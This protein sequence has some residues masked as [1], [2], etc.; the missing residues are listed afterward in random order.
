[1]LS[2]GLCR[3]F[4]RS[5]GGKLGHGGADNTGRLC[6]HDGKYDP[7]GRAR[8]ALSPNSRAET[9]A[10]GS[11]DHCRPA[12]LAG[13]VGIYG[14]VIGAGGGFVLI[15]GLVLLFDLEGVEAVGTVPLHWPPS[16]SAVPDL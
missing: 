7:F 5:I 3:T 1:M 13:V 6:A 4:P 11:A 2:L 16:A 15:P 12:R 9:P 8:T 10:R 14:S